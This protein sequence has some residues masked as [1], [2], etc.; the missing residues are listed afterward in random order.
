MTM[1]LVKIYWKGGVSLLPLKNCRFVQHNDNP[2]RIRIAYNGDVNVI[3]RDG[4]VIDNE[5]SKDKSAIDI[6]IAMIEVS[7]EIVDL[8]QIVFD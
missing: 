4:M 2:K 8:K 3:S 5:L 7:N 6:V 1:K